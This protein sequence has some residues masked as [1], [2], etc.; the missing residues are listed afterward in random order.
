[1]GENICWGL[2]RIYIRSTTFQY[3]HQWHVLVS[4]KMWYNKL[5]W[6]QD[7]IYL[8]QTRFYNRWFPETWFLS[9]WF[10]INFMVRNPAKCLFMLLDV[11]HSLETNLVCGDEILK[12]AN[13]EKVLGVTLDFA[14]HLLNITNQK[15]Q[16]NVAFNALTRVQKY[17]TIEQNKLIFFSFIKWQFNYCPLIWIFCTKRSIRRINER[18]LRLIQQN[19][20]SEFERLLE[21]ANEKWV[22]Q[23]C[24]EFL[25]IEVYKYLNGLSPN[26]MIT[27]FKL[28]QKICITS[29]TSTHLNLKI[30]EQRTLT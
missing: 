4:S 29:E 28:R 20:R 2:T 11:D 10:N 12:N 8:R 1:M 5:C 26:I 3:F 17:M 6:W 27:I 23:K 19:C 14:T 21:N 18:C 25:L 30:L 15:C 16:Q 24:I 7:Y 13:Q 22:P 9:K